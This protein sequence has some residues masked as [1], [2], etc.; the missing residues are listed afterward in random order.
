MGRESAL[1]LGARLELLPDAQPR[2]EEAQAVRRAAARLQE[3]AARRGAA[4][5]QVAALAP[6]PKA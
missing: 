6:R 3:A 1:P 5:A 2:R 4:Q